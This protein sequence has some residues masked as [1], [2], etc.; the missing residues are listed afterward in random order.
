MSLP[1]VEYRFPTPTGYIEAIFAS[2]AVVDVS[3]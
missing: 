1:H 3:R 2:T